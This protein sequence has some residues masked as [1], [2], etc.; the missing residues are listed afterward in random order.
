MQAIVKIIIAAAS[1]H[2]C[3]KNKENENVIIGK[4]T[5]ICYFC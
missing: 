4:I 2:K 5:N 1:A 3:D